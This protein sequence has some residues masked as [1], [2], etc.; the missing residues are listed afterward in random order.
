MARTKKTESVPVRIRFKELKNGCKSIYLDIYVDGKRSYE[1][2]KLSLVPETSSEARAQNDHTLKA[3]N[4]IKAQRILDLANKKP[5]SVMNEKAKMTL[6]DWIKEYEQIK[7]KQ[8][9]KSVS[10]HTQS[11]LAR[12][13]KYN[14]KIKVHE[15][16]LEFIEGFIAFLETQKNRRTKEPL[17]KKTIAL[18]AGTVLWALNLA[19]EMEIIPTNPLQCFDWK[20]IKGD[21]KT[22]VYL[23]IEELGKLKNTSYRREDI[24][25]PFLFSCFSGLRIS[26][27]RGLKW[28]NLIEEDGKAHLELIQKKTGKTLYLPLSRQAREFM[29]EHREDGDKNIFIIPDL[30]TVGRH[31]RLWAKKAG[32]TKD[33]TF[34]V[35][36]HT[37]A[38]LTLTMGADIYTTAELMGHSDVETTQVYG[39]IIDTKKISA[40][41]MIDR[42]F[43]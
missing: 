21:K 23:T 5:L 43:D 19:V 41:Y 10:D 4:A 37:F 18:Y 12:L 9:K 7:V 26:D 1:F 34:H 22:R 30:H 17:S 32:V 25:R 35:S 33:F 14:T 27:V 13:T 42:L 31:L 40:V 24:T 3:A 36:R 39:K 2:L 38:T 20:S 8:G 16:D 29:P 11:C 6:V 28:K 15:V